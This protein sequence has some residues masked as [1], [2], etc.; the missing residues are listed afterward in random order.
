M[1]R[2]SVEFDMMLAVVQ[3]GTDAQI[4]SDD[5]KARARDF[6]REVQALG[7]KDARAFYLR[8]Q[9]ATVRQQLESG[10]DRRVPL[11]PDDDRATAPHVSQEVVEQ[12]IVLSDL[13]GLHEQ[14]CCGLVLEAVSPHTVPLAMHT[15][16]TTTKAM[17]LYF[18]ACQT[19]S[20]CF[21]ILAD[22]A[23]STTETSLSG[24]AREWFD[25]EVTNP[26][27][28]AMTCVRNCD[29]QE[30]WRTVQR[31]I[32]ALPDAKASSQAPMDVI[33]AHMEHVVFEREVEYA[34]MLLTIVANAS[35]VPQSQESSLLEISP[36]QVAL[37]VQ[38]LRDVSALDKGPLDKPKSAVCSL[39]A[40]VLCAFQK[41]REF[42]LRVLDVAP[43]YTA[44]T[45]RENPLLLPGPD[46]HNAIDTELSQPWGGSVLVWRLVR[47]A[48]GL[49]V[50][51][52]E[53]IELARDPSHTMAAGATTRGVFDF[54]RCVLENRVFARVSPMSAYKS[55]IF[56][57]FFEWLIEDNQRITHWRTMADDYYQEHA[58]Q[59]LQEEMLQGYD[60]HHN[61]LF[62]DDFQHLMQAATALFRLPSLSEDRVN[63][64]NWESFLKTA[65]TAHISNYQAFLDL[66]H[67]FVIGFDTASTVFNLFSIAF[68]KQNEVFTWRNLLD[69][70]KG[71][72]DELTQ[73]NTALNADIETQKM[74]I[75]YFDILGAVA[76][77]VHKHHNGATFAFDG[78]FLDWLLQLFLCPVT[79]EIKG[80]V[81]R[82][83]AGLCHSKDAAQYVWTRL[84][85]EEGMLEM[86]SLAEARVRDDVGLARDFM[87]ERSARVYDETRGFLDLLT[88]LLPSFE[89]ARLDP[90]LLLQKVDAFMSLVVDN[91]FANV[92]QQS[93]VDATAKWQLA[94]TLVVFIRRVLCE[95]YPATTDF[96]DDRARELTQQPQ[97]QQPPLRHAG[98][99]L[100]RRLSDDEHTLRT[101]KDVVRLAANNHKYALDSKARTHFMNC[102]EPCMDVLEMTFVRQ[103]AMEPYAPVLQPLAS[104]LLDLVGDV[105]TL[106]SRDFEEK[107]ALKAITLLWHVLRSPRRSHDF[108]SIFRR[109]GGFHLQTIIDSLQ[110][111]LH[112]VRPTV[113]AVPTGE[114]H[115]DVHGQVHSTFTNAV[116]TSI[117]HLLHHLLQSS[118]KN[119]AFLLLGLS[120]VVDGTQRRIRP[121]GPGEPSNCLYSLVYLLDPK[122]SPPLVQCN[123][124]CA[125]LAAQI[126]YVLC[127]FPQTSQPVM[128]YLRDSEDFFSNHMRALAARATGSLTPTQ[129]AAQHHY[130]AWV[131]KMLALELYSP[132]KG[133]SGESQSGLVEAMLEL[134]SP[135]FDSAGRGARR[136]LLQLLDQIS[137]ESD[138]VA[139]P[140]LHVLDIGLVNA[141]FKRCT[142]PRMG[143][144]G[145]QYC[146]I[147]DMI[148]AIRSSIDQVHDEAAVE[149]EL[150]QVARIAE[151]SN[152]NS[153]LRAAKAHLLRA[154]HRAVEVALIKYPYQTS[155]TNRVH[156]VSHMLSEVLN[157]LPENP[158]Q[159]QRLEP[160]LLTVVSDILVTMMSILVDATLMLSREQARAALSTS[161][162]RRIL[163]GIVFGI[164]FRDSTTRMRLNQYGA[165]LFY[166]RI[167][168]ETG[169]PTY[170]E[171]LRAPQ[172]RFLET[173]V[174]DA[175]DSSGFTSVLATS[176]LK[177][178]LRVCRQHSAVWLTYFGRFGH[179]NG[180]V[181][182]LQDTDDAL[183][184]AMTST[185]ER[186]LLVIQEHLARLGFL[187]EVSHRSSGPTLLFTTDLLRVLEQARFIDA[188]PMAEDVHSTRPMHSTA[189][190][191]EHTSRLQRHRSIVIPVIQLV[192]SLLQKCKQQDTKVV[193]HI[194]T[195]VQRHLGQYFRPV[196]KDRV[197][198]IDVQS[199][200]ELCVVTSMFRLLSRYGTTLRTALGA[201]DLRVQ[202]QMVS[203]AVKYSKPGAWRSTQHCSQLEKRTMETYV[204]QIVFNALSYMRTRMDEDCARTYTRS[205]INLVLYPSITQT[206]E[207]KPTLHILVVH[208]EQ[209][210]ETRRAAVQAIE[211]HED[212]L[213][214]VEELSRETLLELDVDP[215]VSRE[216]QQQQARTTLAALIT[217]A[218]RTKALAFMILETS[219]YILWRHLEV[220]L[221]YNT[222]LKGSAVSQQPTAKGPRRLRAGL[223]GQPVERQSFM[224][225]MAT[226]EEELPVGLHLEA[227]SADEIS[228]LR[229]EV[230][231]SRTLS[232]KQGSLLHNLVEEEAARAASQSGAERMAS[233]GMLDPIVKRMKRLRVMLQSSNN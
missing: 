30:D 154:W 94:E 28:I 103:R 201:N 147:G 176:A 65:G 44:D 212:S 179:L 8:P 146:R 159:Q 231:A 6:A 114:E 85:E 193:S 171:R 136:R 34:D 217:E 53:T 108:G 157:R 16:D 128:A 210:N 126:L 43:Q 133:G 195:F 192:V 95:Y 61:S 29:A 119:V 220:Y 203:L 116:A 96:I 156:T 112:D 165:L 82:A 66:L 115:F 64:S 221:Q 181:A 13:L 20:R 227:I 77:H 10:T 178:V 19:L 107:Y 37:L 97:P 188:R 170:S 173:V 40:I 142:G 91:V 180:F 59:R 51:D 105:S 39:I 125:E 98:R 155:P 12:A 143:R 191:D 99:F 169:D 144:E 230:D 207:D 123:P 226:D 233:R 218:K 198:V 45:A 5:F 140:D 58:S 206:V 17:Y 62:T 52:N 48:Y 164:L 100:L 14:T 132:S 213:R 228:T 187:L 153:E 135:R 127:W 166:L 88:V 23:A 9:D 121:P 2:F 122:Q 120:S 76:E 32:G 18:Q 148:D 70:I 57:M 177:E 151:Q 106:L 7:A 167:A 31:C 68:T 175:S 184:R 93:Y 200:E 111:R 183:M 86:A 205:N 80:A 87:N 162:L 21:C 174:Q 185:D 104:Q 139:A 117:L 138:P 67:A 160:E 124:E 72:V 90:S 73:G 25:K 152:T 150:A 74:L 189:L 172:R 137:L 60:R 134:D 102:V 232:V 24:F 83:L 158:D 92:L 11:F 54:L 89:T 118:Q 161:V 214:R 204:N 42:Q 149:A 216:E 194:I 63:P 110:L 130:T 41:H 75:A 55:D 215:D 69:A 79:S 22:E 202:H 129:V 26:L 225:D 186:S 223:F 199:L 145:A 84:C 4:M 229:R 182:Q 1:W 209:A 36:L 211:S 38:L 197:G 27:E 46:G 224:D 50:D 208:M 47:I 101:I 35:L 141:A 81:C 109:L 78:E 113:N 168:R 219:L 71:Y 163:D 190:L 131:L 3:S 222:L 49:M 33:T 196:L 15:A 56:Q